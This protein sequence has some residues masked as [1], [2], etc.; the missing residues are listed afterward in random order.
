M[1]GQRAI[2]RRV[3]RRRVL[4]GLAAAGA[5]RPGRAPAATPQSLTLLAHPV[6][7]SVATGAQAGDIT[8]GWRTR[9][10]I[11]LNWVTLETNPLHERLFREA[12]LTRTSIDFATL[13]NAR[14]VP[15]ITSLFE[16]LDEYVKAQPLEDMAD[17]FP[18]L[19]KAMTFDGKL[20]AVPFRHSTS[21]MHYNADLFAERGIAGPP[22]TIEEFIE[23]ARKMTY[24][25]ADGTQVNGFVISG[26]IYP[27]VVDVARAWDGDFINQELKVVANQAAMVKAI[28]VL[29]DF[30]KEGVLPHSFVQIKDE[31]VNTWMA[32]GRAAM[33]FNGLSRTQFYNDPSKSKFPGKI[34]AA[35]VPVAAELRP[36]FES[37]PVKT[38]FWCFVIPRNS[39]NK[40]AAWGLIRELASKESTLKAALNGNGPVRASTYRDPRIMKQLPYA[41]IEA[42][43]LKYARVP[44]PAFD[45]S[46]RAADI[47]V[48]EM[49]AAVLGTKEPQAAMDEVVRRVQ[50]L[51]H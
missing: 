27:N 20:Y 46:A 28:T 10:G 51:V 47:F 22:N 41:A 13:L 4:A 38:E 5:V 33:T 36:R 39:V 18:G 3:S 43:E 29:R 21:G 50:P 11:A 19:I 7:Q 48:E 30:Y 37:A 24:T 31:D 45:E 14:A 9:T 12:S 8:E 16:P 17:I 6:I 2:S 1:T 25:R 15:R 35:V 42:T 49:Q 32:N 40:E 26:Q 44:L 23:I 34:K